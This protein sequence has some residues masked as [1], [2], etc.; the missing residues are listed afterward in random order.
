MS[1][2][3]LIWKIATSTISALLPLATIKITFNYLRQFL[4][5]DR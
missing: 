3:E 4:V 1:A 2:S 5:N